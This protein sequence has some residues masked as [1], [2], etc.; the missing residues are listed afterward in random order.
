MQ[1]ETLGVSP[2]E[3]AN[4]LPDPAAVRLSILDMLYRAKASHLGSSMSAVEMLIAMYGSTDVR[5]IRDHAP[6]RSRVVVSKGHCAAATYATMAHFGIIP[7][8]L[9]DSYHMNDSL[10]AGHVS[11]AVPAVEHS[12]GAL[13]HG[14]NVA[15]GCAIGL[16][17]RGIRNSLALTLVGDGEIQEGSVWEA[18][19]LASHMKLNNFVALVDNNRISSITDTEKVLD[20][21][22]LAARFGGFGLAVHDVDGHDIGAISSAIREITGGDRPGVVICNTTKGKGV[23]FAEDQPIWHYRSLNDELYAQAK[24]A[25]LAAGRN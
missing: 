7:K 14:I 19:M 18:L 16:R 8:A 15:V 9:L 5:K 10:L 22:P 24:A 11:H 13:G 21:R 17:S 25:I 4:A 23:P 1:T 12:T 6:D 3:A 20:M 2:A